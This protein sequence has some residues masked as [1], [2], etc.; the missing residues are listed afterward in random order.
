MILIRK[1]NK[2]GQNLDQSP[3]P[4]SNCAKEEV[5]EEVLKRGYVP[6]NRSLRKCKR[7]TK[8]LQRATKKGF[9]KNRMKRL[10]TIPENIG[11]LVKVIIR[12]IPLPY[13]LVM[14]MLYGN[15]MLKSRFFI[16]TGLSL[17]FSVAMTTISTL[18]T[19]IRV[20][21]AD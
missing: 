4:L 16:S 13:H 5:I 10:L 21:I 12:L 6:T 17:R 9:P 7:V 18:L 20:N 19:K 2:N 1:T 15:I 14:G 3:F 11:G 8:I